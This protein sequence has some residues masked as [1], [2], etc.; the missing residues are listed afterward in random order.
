MAKLLAVR[1][2]EHAT[3]SSQLARLWQRGGTPEEERAGVRAAAD[4]LEPAH[5][6]ALRAECRLRSSVRA[7]SR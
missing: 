7:S 4:G 2:R 1:R 5:F 6:E 3:L